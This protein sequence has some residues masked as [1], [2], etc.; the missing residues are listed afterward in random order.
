[1]AQFPDHWG[2]NFTPSIHS[3]AEGPTDP[4]NVKL[5]SNLV[6]VVTGAGKGL[7]Y[8]I[9]L[10]YALAGASGIVIASRTQSDLDKL[11]AELRAIN[12]HIDI[13]SQTCDTTKDEEVK[14]LAVATNA[15][16]GRLDVVDRCPMSSHVHERLTH[17]I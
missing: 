15:R 4:R 12:P 16:F 6:V 1:M 17:P 11:S 5:P 13:V 8:H 10:A 3:K 2:V 14:S 7:G 9:A